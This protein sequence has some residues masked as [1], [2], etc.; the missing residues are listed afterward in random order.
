MTGITTPTQNDLLNS[1]ID[2]DITPN[3]ASRNWRSIPKFNEKT[4]CFVGTPTGTT[5]NY[6]CAKLSARFFRNWVT[7]G[8]SSTTQD[9]QLNVA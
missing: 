1:P 8:T 9:Q 4:G 3:D 5:P 7:T 6:Y 2:T